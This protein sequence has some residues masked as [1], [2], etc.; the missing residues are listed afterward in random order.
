MATRYRAVI[1]A[2]WN[3]GMTTGMTTL[4]RVSPPERYPKTETL[5]GARPNEH[6]SVAM[7]P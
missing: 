3:W 6:T 5:F 7:P 2:Q 1:P 4:W